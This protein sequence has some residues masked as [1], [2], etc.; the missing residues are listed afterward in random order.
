VTTLR[1][2]VWTP[3]GTADFL[4]GLPNGADDL[5]E[6]TEIPDRPLED[7]RLPEVEALIPPLVRNQADQHYD[8]RT[9]LAAAPRLVYVQTLTAGVDWIVADMP[10][11]VELCSVRGAYDELMAELLLAGI[12]AV[13]K[14]FGHYYGAQT[15]GA[16]EPEQVR[17]LGGSRV[18]FVGYGSIAA[19]LEQYLAPFRVETRRIARSARPG[20]DTLADLPDLLP[21]ADVVVVLTPLTEATR[22]LVD[23][24]FV[25]AMKPGALLVNG[26]RGL[27]AD[28]GAIRAAADRGA[29][30][31]F[32]DVTDPEPL[33]PGHPLWSAPGVFITPHIG[34]LVADNQD[35]AFAV[36]R[37]NLA[38]WAH[39]E[40]PENAVRAGY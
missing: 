10:A 22:G 30:R 33:P 14:E 20:V 40:P 37:A 19:C 2:L 34:S 6:I 38:R 31:A 16:W 3:S 13:Y 36:V 26:A 17:V 8:L 11:G 35:R 9:L 18:L 27:V 32:L 12:L 7:P 15:R 28:T 4:R 5:L 25:A 29:I 21:W 24:G 1:K 23:D 39:G